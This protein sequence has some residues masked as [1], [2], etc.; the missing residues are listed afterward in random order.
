M[1]TDWS[2]L[3][4]EDGGWRMEDGGWIVDG[5]GWRVEGG[6][7]KVARLQLSMLEENHTKDSYGSG[8]KP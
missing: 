5:G 7:M 2:D 8:G 4:V 6:G 3:R 1:S